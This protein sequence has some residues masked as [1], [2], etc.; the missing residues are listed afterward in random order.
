MAPLKVQVT[1]YIL[2]VLTT[3]NPSDLDSHYWQIFDA[4][5]LKYGVI[6]NKY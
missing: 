1:K 6:N 2:F 5:R 4:A 3:T